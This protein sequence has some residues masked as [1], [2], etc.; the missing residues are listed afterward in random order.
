MGKKGS[1]KDAERS[2]VPHRSRSLPLLW[3]P[4]GDE[5]RPM[6]PISQVR[7]RIERFAIKIRESC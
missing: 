4:F 7:M 1:Q 3:Q 2:I 6:R 5:L